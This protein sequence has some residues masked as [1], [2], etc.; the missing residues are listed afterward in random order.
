MDVIP[1][2]LFKQRFFRI[3]NDVHMTNGSCTEINR[4]FRYITVNGR[5]VLKCILTW[6]YTAKYNQINVN[7]SDI[8][9]SCS[10]NR[11]NSLNFS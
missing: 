2:S 9:K 11:V 5:K 8:R 10:K 6:S 4:K 1:G 3:E 7:H